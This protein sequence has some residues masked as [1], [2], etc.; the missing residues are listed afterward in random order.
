MPRYD[1]VVLQEGEGT[2]DHALIPQTAEE[3][4]M[5]AND[6]AERIRPMEN[7]MVSVNGGMGKI[8][9]MYREDGGVKAL[10][11]IRDPEHGMMTKVVTLTPDMV[12]MQPGADL[13]SA[14]MPRIV[15]REVIPSRLFHRS[16]EIVGRYLDVWVNP[17]NPLQLMA[18][19][20]LDDTPK[21]LAMQKMLTGMGGPFP[22]PVIAGESMEV[23]RRPGGMMNGPAGMLT[24]GTPTAVPKMKKAGQKVQVTEEMGG[25]GGSN[26]S[27]NTSLDNMTKVDFNNETDAAQDMDTG[28]LD[29]AAQDLG[30]PQTKRHQNMSGET[31]H[32]QEFNDDLMTQMEAQVKRANA[33]ADVAN[34]RAAMAELERNMKRNFGDLVNEFS[35]TKSTNPKLQARKEGTLDFVSKLANNDS[36]IVDMVMENPGRLQQE[37][38]NFSVLVEAQA[39]KEAALAQ[40]RQEAEQAAAEA[41]RKQEELRNMHRARAMGIIGDAGSVGTSNFSFGYGASSS[42]TSSS[43]PAPPTSTQALGSAED[44]ARNDRDYHVIQRLSHGLVSVGGDQANYSFGGEPRVYDRDARIL[45][46]VERLLNLGVTLEMIDP[47][48]HTGASRAKRGREN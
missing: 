4:V 33:V 6:A 17:D 21:G 13:I 8:M 48:A 30:V 44:R 3:M 12:D 32:T 37:M 19:R 28:K 40:A 42:S 29:T 46:K 24:G 7:V 26:Y 18:L 39:D 9:D 38:D 5:F 11:K 35:K 23:D 36:G 47:V 41:E 43:T 20:A 31:T 1:V 45:G 10:I 34:A 14:I 16:P 15:S 27:F 2:D 25:K 22:T